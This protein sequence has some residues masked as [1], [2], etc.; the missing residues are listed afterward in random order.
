M[1]RHF[2]IIAKNSAIAPQY[3][4]PPNAMIVLWSAFGIITRLFTPEAAH[5]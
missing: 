3:K 2:P 4:D 5:S 1:L